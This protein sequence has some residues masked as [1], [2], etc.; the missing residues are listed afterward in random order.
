MMADG[1]K[2][3][4]VYMSEVANIQTPAARTH[5]NVMAVLILKQTIADIQNGRLVAEENEAMEDDEA[6]IRDLSFVGMN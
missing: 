2:F 5:A 6:D 3:E 1:L 4:E